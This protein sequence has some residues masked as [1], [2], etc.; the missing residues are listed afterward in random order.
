[1][2]TSQMTWVTFIVSLCSICCTKVSV[3]LLYR[4]ILA[5]SCKQVWNFA[6]WAAIGV[7][8]VLFVAVILALCLVCDP[9]WAYWM[10]FDL[11]W[12]ASWHCADAQWLNYFVGIVSVISDFYAIVL[13]LAVLGHAEL[14]IS[15]KQ[16]WT[17]YF[18]FLLSIRY[19]PSILN[20]S[21]R[22]Y[23][24]DLFQRRSSWYRKNILAGRARPPPRH[25][26]DRRGPA[27]LVHSRSAT[28]NN[29]RLRTR[30]PAGLYLGSQ[31]L[32]QLRSSIPAQQAW[33]L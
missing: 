25:F 15:W 1:M 21:H 16:R 26:L 8:A 2:L 18:F 5:P 17:T 6:V 3:L 31:A 22:P 28:D 30:D 33:Q 4:R 10:S 20:S 19:V 23:I 7:T 13:P 11:T 27:H 24:A 9:L 14:H 12:E 32:G 29:L